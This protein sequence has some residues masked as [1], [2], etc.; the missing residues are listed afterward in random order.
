MYNCFPYSKVVQTSQLWWGSGQLNF[1]VHLTR[2]ISSAQC[3]QLDMQFRN[4]IK[5][6]SHAWGD[7]MLVKQAE[8][9]KKNKIHHKFPVPRRNQNEHYLSFVV[10]F[11]PY[12]DQENLGDL[13]YFFD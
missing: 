11:K 2:D 8:E 7:G 4:A 12:E 13:E 10:L 6:T 1:K 3:W 5:M 9:G